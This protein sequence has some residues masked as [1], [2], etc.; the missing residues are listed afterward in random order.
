MFEKM[1]KGLREIDGKTIE[2]FA[3]GE[4]PV[5]AKTKV[6]HVAKWQNDG[7]TRGVTPA[8]FV[9]TA[10]AANQGWRGMIA[11]GVDEMLLGKG[12]NSIKW[13]AKI[14]ANDIGIACNRIRT[15]QLKRSFTYR[16]K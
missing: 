12:I 3:K 16:I 8:Q 11:K 7:T 2:I 15:G 14:I 9:E 10:E 5:K 6:Q 13:V 1:L 4:Y